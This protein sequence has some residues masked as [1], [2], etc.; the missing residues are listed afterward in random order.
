MEDLRY[1][2]GHYTMPETF[3]RDTL[4]SYITIIKKFP[5]KLK[6]EAGGLTVSQLNTPYRPDGWTVAHKP[7]G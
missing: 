5:N 2:I 1:P 6:S 4:N 7:W 3:S